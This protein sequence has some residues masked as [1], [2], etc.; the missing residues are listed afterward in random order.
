MI[1]VQIFFA[2]CLKSLSFFPSLHLEA[3]I[4]RRDGPVPLS[5]L[6]GFAS[7]S[8][9]EISDFCISTLNNNNIEDDEVNDF[10]V[11]CN[12]CIDQLVVNQGHFDSIFV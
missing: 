5:L 4:R 2:C 3:A 9:E 12:A 10:S 1:K 8:L 11:K 7:C 6:S